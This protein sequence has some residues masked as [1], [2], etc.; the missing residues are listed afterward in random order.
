MSNKPGVSWSEAET[1]TDNLDT[2]IRNLVEN[3]TSDNA[4]CLVRSVMD[5]CRATSQVTQ[6][7]PEML[8]QPA[9]IAP[10]DL[11]RSFEAVARLNNEMYRWTSCLS[12]NGSYVGEPEGL[13]KRNIR[14]IERIMDA[15]RTAILGGGINR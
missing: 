7:Y 9:P 6:E 14:E 15:C 13:L 10:E 11:R 12:Y 2:E 4:V 3:P 8:P 5:A 1:L